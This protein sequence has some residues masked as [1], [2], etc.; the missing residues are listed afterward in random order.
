MICTFLLWFH[1]LQLI[2]RWTVTGLTGLKPKWSQVNTTSGR[3]AR[4]GHPSK[5]VGCQECG[6][7]ALSR[8]W[9]VSMSKFLS[10]WEAGHFQSHDVL[11]PICACMAW[12]PSFIQWWYHQVFV[13]KILLPRPSAKH[14]KT[15]CACNPGAVN[16]SGK[17][18]DAFHSRSPI[19]QND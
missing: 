16:K 18:I 9:K 2:P 6:D 10:L 12:D 14:L 7:G 11:F 1:H 5:P 4:V 17:Q 19:C 15:C 3:G 8:S 13:F